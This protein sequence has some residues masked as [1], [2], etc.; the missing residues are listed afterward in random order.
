M[1]RLIMLLAKSWDPPRD[2]TMI[3]GSTKGG[4]HGKDMLESQDNRHSERRILVD[5]IQKISWFFHIVSFFIQS[6]VFK[7][8]VML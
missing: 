3:T 2:L 5:T 6:L 4:S 1:E 8:G 7:G